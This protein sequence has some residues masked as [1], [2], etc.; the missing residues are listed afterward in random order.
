MVRIAPRRLSNAVEDWA[1][2]VWRLRQNA[3]VSRLMLPTVPVVGVLET[4][5]ARPRQSLPPLPVPSAY[6]MRFSTAIAVFLALSTLRAT[7][8][9]LAESP[10]HFSFSSS[11]NTI[12]PHTGCFHSKRAASNTST[13]VVS[14]SE[15]RRVG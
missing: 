15:E 1:P 8:S 9:S 4:S 11:E 10:E 6:I 3:N 12:V 2:D 5:V 14:R 7:R 13:R